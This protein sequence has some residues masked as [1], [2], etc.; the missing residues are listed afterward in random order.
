MSVVL[1][2]RKKAEFQPSLIKQVRHKLFLA[3]IRKFRKSGSI[4]FMAPRGSAEVLRDTFAQLN[5]F[6]ISKRSVMPL[7]HQRII[8]YKSV[9]QFE[10]ISFGAAILR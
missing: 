5:D 10:H 3:A 7:M 1:F 6:V 2:F 9:L 4:S 8:T